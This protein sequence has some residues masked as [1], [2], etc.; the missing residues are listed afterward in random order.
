MLKNI[1]AD[2]ENK[3]KN[4][5]RKYLF[6]FAILYFICRSI[7]LLSNHS[8]YFD[9]AN[10]WNIA[11]YLDLNE[12][13][14]LMKY[15]GHLFLWYVI[16][17]PFAKNDLFYPYSMQIINW[18]FAFGAILVMWKYAPF[19][20][21][22]K[23]C[24]TL[25]LPFKIYA[26]LARCYSFGILLLFILASLY[27]KRFKH[28]L[29]YSLLIII[30]ANTSVMALVGAFSLGLMFIYDLFKSGKIE[31]ISNKTLMLVF[32]IFAAG[33]FLV[34]AQLAGFLLPSYAVYNTSYTFEF[35]FMRFY[36]TFDIFHVCFVLLYSFLLI[37]A[38][39]FFKNDFKPFF[40][41][42]LTHA[43][44]IYIF[45]Q[46]YAGEC[47]HFCFIFIYFILS[48]W[49]Y[50]SEHKLKT[51][52]Q[53]IYSL[54]FTVFCLLLIMYP[55][56]YKMF[57][58]TSNDLKE[59]IIQNID[60]Y[61]HAKIFF[62]PCFSYTKEIIPYLEKYKLDFYDSHGN[63]IRDIDAFSV[64]YKDMEINF[65][66]IEN[67]LHDGEAGYIITDT[68]NNT[69]FLKNIKQKENL[70]NLSVMPYKT[71]LPAYIYVVKKIRKVY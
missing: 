17:M 39:K 71:L 46:V 55:S 5:I 18:L 38:G 8:I 27:P 45:L 34:L 54:L 32:G 53:I 25:S 22:I 58:G 49:I 51:N 3:D 14:K 37:S 10:A 11:A 9:E 44:L 43:I 28:P 62:Y 16:L 15:E 31:N 26:L 13:L 59:H 63:S 21:Y 69:L 56:D 67:L 30:V 35:H 23:A 47:W 7:I 42:F 33:A 60:D 65:P 20:S 4:L 36:F 52:F 61:S 40:F 19:N 2:L 6:V 57:H 24:I 70:S 12:I 48:V 41:L 68:R 1:L 29:I 50:L 66:A 64:Q